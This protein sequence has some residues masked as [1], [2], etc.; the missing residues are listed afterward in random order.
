MAKGHRVWVALLVCRFFSKVKL[1][2]E[3]KVK[4][5]PALLQIVPKFIQQ[6]GGHLTTI[7]YFAFW[8]A[9]RLGLKSFCNFL[10]F[11]SS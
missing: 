8:V 7:L 2:Q 9:Y 10:F 5:L 3:T 6:D 1:F 11:N 4:S